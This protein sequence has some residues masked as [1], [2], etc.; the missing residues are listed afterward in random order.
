MKRKTIV[1]IVENDGKKVNL[2]L[3]DRKKEC[4]SSILCGNECKCT[5][6][7]TPAV[8]KE[9][10]LLDTEEYFCEYCCNFDKE[11]IGMDG[12]ALCKLTNTLAYCEDCAKDC[13]FF[14]IP[15]ADA[16]KVNHGKWIYYDMVCSYDG[17]KSGYACSECRAAVDEDVFDAEEF[18]KKFCGNCGAKMDGDGK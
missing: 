13:K 17:L 11:C 6:D 12:T 14:N 4:N 9:I 18:H 5:F 7:E 1:D 8:E 15:A 3:C 16:E 10:E 2:Y